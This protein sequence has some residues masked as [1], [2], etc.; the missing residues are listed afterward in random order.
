MKR[1]FWTYFRKIFKYHISC[2]SVQ[3]EP[4]CLTRTDRWTD[5]PDEAKS[6][7]SQILRM[8]L[9]KQSIY[10]VFI[11]QELCY[12]LID[13]YNY[14]RNMSLSIFP[15]NEKAASSTGRSEINCN[16]YHEGEELSYEILRRVYVSL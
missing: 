15:S 3:R 10:F 13:D 14:Y 5:R 9:V 7:F 1:H 16:L 6:S 12:E 8:R 11:T 2:K 4:R